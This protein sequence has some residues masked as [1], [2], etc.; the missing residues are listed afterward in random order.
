M[1]KFLGLIMVALLFIACG[2]DPDTQ[3]VKFNYAPESITIYKRESSDSEWIQKANTTFNYNE[4]KQLIKMTKNNYGTVTESYDYSYSSDGIEQIVR[5]E[6]DDETGD[7]YR[8]Q[9]FSVGLN[10][11]EIEQIQVLS[12]DFRDD[13]TSKYELMYERDPEGRLK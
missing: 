6:Y 9:T 10:N 8:E 1:R 12:K 13:Y 4:K 3:D 7:I 2:D 11:S 5:K